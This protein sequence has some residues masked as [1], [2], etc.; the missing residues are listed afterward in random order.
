LGPISVELFPVGAAALVA[1]HREPA[2]DL[3]NHP[4]L[5][6]LLSTQT[7]TIISYCDPWKSFAT[8]REETLFTAGTFE[9]AIQQVADA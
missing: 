5:H 3:P 7:P 1:E 9:V 4:V 6:F 8:F 2:E